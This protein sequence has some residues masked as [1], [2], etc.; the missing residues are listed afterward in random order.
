ML[1]VGMQPT[2]ELPIFPARSDCI[3]R[4]KTTRAGIH[5]S[6]QVSLQSEIAEQN[7][8][9][10]QMK[11]CSAAFASRVVRCTLRP[12]HVFRQAAGL[13]NQGLGDDLYGSSVPVQGV[14][15]TELPN[16]LRSASFRVGN[17]RSADVSPMTI[18]RQPVLGASTTVAEQPPAPG[19]RQAL[20]E[21]TAA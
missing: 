12:A 7:V 16:V 19:D 2:T 20:F 10:S 9:V 15:V 8:A 14:F 1:V 18:G 11:C 4:A 17:R 5:A 3:R 21:D 6:R 13:A